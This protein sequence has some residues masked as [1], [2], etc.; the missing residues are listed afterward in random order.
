MIKKE[1]KKENNNGNNNNSVEKTN[2]ILLLT[3]LKHCVPY[4]YMEK[5]LALEQSSGN[6]YERCQ[7]TARCVLHTNFNIESIVIVIVYAL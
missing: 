5:K 4:K 2:E 3:A 7:D 6:V 1:R